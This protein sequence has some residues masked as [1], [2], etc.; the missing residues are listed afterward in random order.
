M[1]WQRELLAISDFC[2]CLRNGPSIKRKQEGSKL[3]SLLLLMVILSVFYCRDV[4]EYLKE[5]INKAYKD[6]KFETN[7]AY[8][9]KQYLALQRI[10]NNEHKTKYPRTFAS[11]ATGLTREQCNTAL[12]NEFLEEL[13][14][15]DT[16]I[17][18]RLFSP[19]D[20]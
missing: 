10:L 15:E 20:S 9:D 4:G 6:N 14:K 13:A 16:S 2:S 7:L 11:S 19:K 1:Q 5:T 17:F 8:W 3:P 12:S 18:K